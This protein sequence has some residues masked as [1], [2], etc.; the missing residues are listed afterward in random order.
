MKQLLLILAAIISTG[1]LHAQHTSDNSKHISNQDISRL[2]IQTRLDV[3]AFMWQDFEDGTVPPTSWTLTSGTTPSSWVVG[4]SSIYT[5]VSGDYFAICR[6]DETYIPEGQDEKLYSP[7]LNLTGLSDAKLTFWF[8][9]SRYWGIT[10]Y[11]NYD[12][13]VLVS[14]DGGLTFPDTIWSELSTDTSAWASW[15]WIY[16]ETD[17]TA[18][19]GEANVQLCFRYV[20]FDGAD[21]ALEDIAITFVTSMNETVSIPL[22]VYPNPATD[23]MFVEGDGIRYIQIYDMQGRLVL[24]DVLYDNQRMLDVSVLHNG[25]YILYVSQNSSRTSGRFVVTG[26]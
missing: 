6:F 3:T 19:T 8:L 20:G 26:K 12:L 5:P 10:P 1:L 17:I 22:N 2:N 25:N 14:T 24:S 15:E 16:T 21:A 13:Q 11:N 23:M 4:D 18:Y 9:F 7:V